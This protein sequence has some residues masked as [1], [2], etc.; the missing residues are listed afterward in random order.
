MT[1]PVYKSEATVTA[2]ESR[3]RVQL[4]RLLTV[5]A[6]CEQLAKLLSVSGHS[7]TPGL[8]VPKNPAPETYAYVLEHVGAQPMYKRLRGARTR[9]E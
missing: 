4:S 8:A 7:K 5:A 6:S 1:D 9:E 2:L 3:L